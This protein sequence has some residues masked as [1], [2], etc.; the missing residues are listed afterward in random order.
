M[1]WP[2]MNQ[3]VYPSLRRS[4]LIGG[5]AGTAYLAEMVLDMRVVSNRYDDLVLW[6]GFV[7]R[8]RVRQRLL[9]AAVHYVL[10]VTLAFAYGT[11]S[12]WLPRWPGWVRGVV[13][14]QVE[15]ALLYPGVPV[16]NAVHP[17]VRSGRLPTLLTWRYFWV[18]IARHVAFGA[19]LGALLKD[20]QR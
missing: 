3:P 17:E 20:R 13:F 19:T 10:S 1:R 7:A 4:A 14:V 6:G 12:P 16:L 18:E 5:I 8:N 11:V 15:N 2:V 9:G